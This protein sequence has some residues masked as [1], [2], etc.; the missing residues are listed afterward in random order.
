LRIVPYLHPLWQILALVLAGW[1]LTLGLRLRAARR[2]GA[3]GMRPLLTRRHATSGLVFAIMLAVGY[4]AGPLTLGLVRDEP[5]FRSGHALFATLTLLLIVSGALLG[6]KLLRGGGP[7]TRE[8]HVFCMGV[9]LFLVLVT[10]M[11]GLG[12]LP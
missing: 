3:W 9:G 2:R 6:L 4:M 10:V 5:V 7:G 1:T 11:F 8:L 12:L